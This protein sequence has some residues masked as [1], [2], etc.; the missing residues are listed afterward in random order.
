MFMEKYDYNKRKEHLK[1][2]FDDTMHQIETDK[3]LQEIVEKSK[4]TQLVIKHDE[5]I[6]VPK[7]SDYRKT[8]FLV[9]KS[10]TMEAAAKYADEEKLVAV[11]NFA[12]AT[13][14]GGGVDKG[15]VAQ[16]ECLCRV[17]TLF[18]CINSEKTMDLFYN[19]HR[20]AKNPLHNDDI[21]YTRDVCVFKDDDYNDIEYPFCV[22]VI[23]CAAPNLRD[24]PTNNMNLDDGEGVKITDN[25]L[26]ELHKSRARKI[27][28]SAAYNEV[29]VVILGAFGCGVFKNPPEIVAEAYKEVIQ[30]FYGYFDVVE[31]AI[32]CNKGNM[33][34][35][36]TF[37][38]IMESK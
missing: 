18:P 21:I 12:S 16:E 1:S 33:E 19:P 38:R 29:D 27:L 30:E 32:Y 26:L 20:Q 31:F 34:N 25:D 8:K 28:A 6:N 22:D 14:P 2:V 23:T 13:T 35:Y 7:I 4:D 24:K 17:S 15:S 5:K 37:K 11:L 36:N 3:E 9:T 10:K